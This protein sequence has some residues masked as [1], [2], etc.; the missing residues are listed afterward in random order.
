MP[1]AYALAAEVLTETLFEDKERIRMFLAEQKAHMEAQFISSGNRYASMRATS[2]LGERFAYNDLTHGYGY[3]EFL[4]N[5]VENFDAKFEELKHGLEVICK[6]LFGR[7][8]VKIALA[9]SE[10]SLKSAY[11]Y[12]EN[13]KAALTDGADNVSVNIMHGYKNEAFIAESQVNYCIQAFD[14]FANG[15][16]CS[17]KLDVLSNVINNG[18]LLREIREKGGAYGYGID[19][20]AYGATELM[21]YRDPNLGR[22]YGVYKAIPEFLNGFNPN[23]REMLQYILGAVNGFDRPQKPNA[24]FDGCLYRYFSNTTVETLQRRR[25]EILST[26]AA[27]IRAYAD[28]LEKALKNSYICTFGSD[29]K[30]NESKGLFERVVKL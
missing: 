16:K 27:D 2:Y 10:S 24:L 4:K 18:Y 26:T 6:K 3:Y 28:I 15:I 7:N 13:F 17:G 19:I 20:G 21:S 29:G 22:T 30:I 9:C 1:Q 25:N 11:P 12:F 23:D 8:R 14:S 5:T